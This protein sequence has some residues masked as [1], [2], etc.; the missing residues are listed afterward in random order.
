MNT[1][2]FPGLS[3]R[4][5]RRVTNI[6][7]LTGIDD[8]ISAVSEVLGVDLSFVTT[9]IRTKE[10]AEART[11]AIG[12]ILQVDRQITLKSLGR[13]FGNRDH[14]TMSYNRDLYSDLYNRD[15]QF[16]AKVDAVLK[17]A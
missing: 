10:I 3:E 5:Q 4:D 11:I 15:K 14:S 12:L 6:R 13:I 1:L 17:I 16:T 9:K 2:M 8:I 7:K